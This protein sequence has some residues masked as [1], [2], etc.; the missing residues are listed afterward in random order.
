MIRYEISEKDISIVDSILK[1]EF[2]PLF[3]D[4]EIFEYETQWNSS[5]FWAKVLL[6]ST[7]PLRLNGSRFLDEI[8]EYNA[9]HNSFISEKYLRNKCWIRLVNDSIVF[10]M[11]FCSL[12]ERVSRVDLKSLNEDDE[13]VNHVLFLKHFVKKYGFPDS[14]YFEINIRD[15]EEIY[16]TFCI[17]YKKMLSKDQLVKDFS[18]EYEGEIYRYRLFNVVQKVDRTKLALNTLLLLF[19]E[20]SKACSIER[21]RYWLQL[22]HSQWFCN[23]TK[24]L[25]DELKERLLNDFEE[26]LSKEDDL[27]DEDGIEAK[28]IF[29]NGPRGLFYNLNDVEILQAKGYEKYQI[30]NLTPFLIWY[31]YQDVLYYDNYVFRESELRDDIVK[32][33]DAFVDDVFLFNQTDK[34]LISLFPKRP[35]LLLC[36][37]DRLMRESPARLLKF[38]DE[39]EY[40]AIFF[41][42]FL[43]LCE[44]SFSRKKEINFFLKECAHKSLNI[45]ITKLIQIQDYE[46]LSYLF[47]YLIERKYNS[48]WFDF[49]EKMMVF[50][51]KSCQLHEKSISVFLNVYDRCK[52]DIWVNRVNR[53]RICNFYY[54]FYLYEHADARIK[55]AVFDRII[56]LYEET[57]FGNEKFS[58]W[59]EWNHLEDIKWSSFFENLWESDKERVPNF[60]QEVFKHL[61]LDEKESNFEKKWSSPKK[62]RLHLK[63]LCIAYQKMKKYGNNEC[64]DALEFNI[65]TMLQYCFVNKF[66]KSKVAIFDSLYESHWGID[67]NTELFL[68]VT[69]T[70][71]SFSK[72]NR[73]KVLVALGK[74][75]D[76]ILMVKAF[77]LLDSEEDRTFLK[78]FMDFSV[79]VDQKLQ[80]FDDCIIFLRNL[81]STHIN[82]NYA[83]KYL[84]HLDVQVSE[85]VNGEIKA[86]FVINTE[87]LKL[88]RMFWHDDEKQLLAYKCPYKDCTGHFQNEVEY[89]K[90]EQLYLLAML[91]IKYGKNNEA[92]VFINR[93][94]NN[95]N[96]KYKSVKLYLSYYNL[97]CAHYEYLHSEINAFLEGVNEKFQKHPYLCLVNLRILYNEKK[98]DTLYD[99]YLSLNIPKW[100]KQIVEKKDLISLLANENDSEIVQ[101]LASKGSLVQREE[102]ASLITNT[103]KHGELRNLF[104]ELILQDDASR[105]KVIPDSINKHENDV[106]LFVVNQLCCCLQQLLEKINSLMK[107]K[108]KEKNDLLKLMLNQSLKI[109]RY[110]FIDESPQ[111]RSPSGKESGELDFVLKL[112]TFSIVLESVRCNSFDADVKGHILKVFNYEP[113]RR[114]FINLMYYEG[115]SSSF[116]DCWKQVVLKTTNNKD[117]VY[118]VQNECIKKEDISN[119][120]NN[121]SIKVLKNTHKTN[122]D[123]YHI[124]VNLNYAERD[125]KANAM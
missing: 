114:I 15:F 37:L 88:Y 1:D 103:E 78:Q 104:G 3:L 105:F 121:A 112:G 94:K 47:M 32:I 80:F 5:V 16:Q 53:F 54:L 72:E 17:F 98:F 91:N 62:L 95:S 83:D 84:D 7:Q 9:T 52:S 30:F 89:L 124:L 61:N 100:S 4:K 60:C 35:F 93:V 116:M 36:F 125:K 67:F 27:I 14:R 45:M 55:A 92:G 115:E 58:Y 11:N 117:V 74:S 85:R 2:H 106:G 13:F 64:A 6:K 113:S 59:D 8:K 38:V 65:A 50:F 31:K 22:F 44:E 29:F 34:F 90:D 33:I 86:P 108:E 28:R 119:R 57:V 49:Y 68:F 99:Y 63:I 120:Y 71:K 23:I 19:Q 77:N 40:G 111:G 122:L 20:D 24:L 46:Q 39:K 87:L 82:D 110:E 51:E 123:F 21:V 109:L 25:P 79:E 48:K 81:Y 102:T 70:I 43:Q 76:L 101:I 96:D 56:F 97:D 10:S 75:D 12:L 42:S 66:E 26:I 69:E 118:P 18:L 41:C 73:Q 107:L